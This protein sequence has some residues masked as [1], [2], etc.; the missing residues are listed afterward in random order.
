MGL[1]PAGAP[2][3]EGLPPPTGAFQVTGTAAPPKAPPKKS[4]AAPKKVTDHHEWLDAAVVPIMVGRTGSVIPGGPEDVPSDDDDDDISDESSE[5]SEEKKEEEPLSPRR[6]SGGRHGHDR[7]ALVASHL[8]KP[9]MS[10]RKLCQIL[11]WINTMK[12]WPKPLD[13]AT[14]H[15]DMC[16]GLL[17]CKLMKALC[18]DTVYVNLHKRP[19]SRKPAIS[20]IEQ[21]LSVIWRGGK[22]NNSRVPS[23]ADI[24]SG[25]SD[26][27]TIMLGEIF[28][29]YTMRKLR[30]SVVP[31]MLQ[32]FHIILK[33]YGRPIKASAMR[34]PYTGLFQHFNSGVSLF[35]SIFHFM[36]VSEVRTSRATTQVDPKV[37]Y[38]QPSNL[39]EYR[40]NITEVFKI[41]K[42]I[43]IDCFWEVDEFV[44]FHDTDFLLLQLYKI[45]DHF[46]EMRCALPPAHGDVTGVTADGNGEPMV[47]NMFFRQV[48]HDLTTGK[49]VNGDVLVGDGKKQTLKAP[50]VVKDNTVLPAHLPPGL[51]CDLTFEQPRQS[52]EAPMPSQFSGSHRSLASADKRRKSF[53]ILSAAD[54]F[55]VEKM[56][57]LDFYEE[58]DFS[59][60]FAGE[61]G[62]SAEVTAALKSLEIEYENAEEALEEKEKQL[63]NAYIGLEAQEQSLQPS[64]YNKMFADLE[65][66]MGA[67]EDERKALQE[68]YDTKKAILMATPTAASVPSPQSS[69]G[70]SRSP[71]KNKD[72]EEARKKKMESGWISATKKK[73]T[74]NSKYATL[75]KESEENIARTMT[76]DGKNF[77]SFEASSKDPSYAHWDAFAQKM[78]NRQDQW[79]MQRE[80]QAL[81]MVRKLKEER[82]VRPHDAFRGEKGSGN[83]LSEM[84]QQ[85]R[86]EELRMMSLEEER[87]FMVIHQSFKAKQN[88]MTKAAAER[89]RVAAGGTPAKSP[90]KESILQAEQQK[91]AT[92]VALREQMERVAEDEAE[93]QGEDDAVDAM[94]SIQRMNELWH[95]KEQEE[96]SVSTA[97]V[98]QQQQLEVG[99]E[100]GDLPWLTTARNLIIKERNSERQ[101]EFVVV[102]G[103]SIAPEDP[104]RSKHYA[105]HWG[106]NGSTSGFISVI[107]IAE[108]KQANTDPSNMIVVLKKP[109]SQAVK[110][111]G[112]LQ[113]LCI[114]TNSFMDCTKYRTGL[115]ALMSEAGH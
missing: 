24:Y 7:K 26:K 37:I 52:D 21:A 74:H 4:K 56:P 107:D 103:S 3:T 11:R 49:N 59:V 42:S 106:N 92:Q 60:G 5:E 95:K 81:V 66:K 8:K 39:A 32:W 20:N 36:G 54:T 57:N 80:Q 83:E 47:K 30:K 90:R 31:E 2:P 14:V 96:E 114:R 34:P 28:E 86:V 109:N 71:K 100:A 40:S 76:R 102:P 10:V 94:A 62:K 9:K 110:N 61:T 38:E 22:V 69:P 44:N 78:R 25:K 19:L 58:D 13:L 64:I 113:M 46:V 87:R 72:A 18:P 101:F 104:L 48:G 77:T 84:M 6:K 93:K 23:A 85:I 67:L 63:A 82:K 35:C 105:L 1:P 29:V 98:Q 88:T 55:V 111:S 108:V 17:L 73:K 27:I 91:L 15:I 79:L 97:P 41:M 16:N 45:Y 51:V 89:A 115:Q 75:Q 53:A 99:A 68:G 12:V 33:Q 43:K 50:V 65:K 70:K 112:G